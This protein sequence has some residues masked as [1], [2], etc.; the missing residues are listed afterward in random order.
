MVSQEGREILL[1]LSA[2]ENGVGSNNRNDLPWPVAVLKPNK[3]NKYK[4]P[5]NGKRTDSFNNWQMTDA[6]QS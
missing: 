4:V 6:R 3:P 2:V 1:T 5:V